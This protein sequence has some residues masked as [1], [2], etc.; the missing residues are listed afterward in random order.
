[1]DGERVYRSGDLVRMVDGGVEFLRRV[2]DQVKVRGVR[3]E[4][5]EVE[6]ALV[7]HPAVAEAAVVPRT[8]ASGTDLVAFVVPRSPEPP[9]GLAADLRPQVRQGLPAAFGPAAVQLLP[10]LP[11]TTPGKL[12]RRALRERAE[13]V[14]PAG[15]A[16]AD[17]DEL[18]A[19]WHA[20]LEAGPA[21]PAAGF[22]D[23]G[24]HSLAAARL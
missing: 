6:A 21:D 2:D 5:A 17:G 7:R 9:G 12:D 10:A 16:P 23:L 18:A 20:A 15:P 4:P 19:A 11:K 22:L 14:A 8:R 24:G 3:V 1:A 13:A